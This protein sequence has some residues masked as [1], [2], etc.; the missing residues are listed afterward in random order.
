LSSAKGPKTG[1]A[2]CDQFWLKKVLMVTD[3]G[4][5]S[6]GRATEVAGTIETAGTA[7]IIF[8][9]VTPNPRAD[10]TMASAELTALKNGLLNLPHGK[11]N[12]NNLVSDIISKVCAG[13]IQKTFRLGTLSKK[14]MKILG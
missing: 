4:V 13:F 5:L 14:F 6:V 3:P 8:S 10:E 9:H 11:C 12:A 1:R 7:C 2:L